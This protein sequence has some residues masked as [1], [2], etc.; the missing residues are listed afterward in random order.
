MRRQIAGLVRGAANGVERF[1]RDL[2]DQS[3][4]DLWRSGSDFTRK[5]PAVVFGLPERV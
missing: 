2:R 4:E 3:V 5:Q 1:S